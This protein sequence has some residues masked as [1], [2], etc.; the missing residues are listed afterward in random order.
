MTKT[1]TN[2]AALH[3]ARTSSIAPF[4]QLMA[5][6]PEF[7]PRAEAIRSHSLT[8]DADHKKADKTALS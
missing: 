4:Y 5:F 3:V 8:Y 7:L 1:V 2:V 6:T